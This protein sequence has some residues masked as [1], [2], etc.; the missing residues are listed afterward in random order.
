MISVSSLILGHHFFRSGLI[1]DYVNSPEEENQAA[2]MLMRSQEV[3]VRPFKHDNE[4][5]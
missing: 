1:A 5:V 3:P 2:E 4:I